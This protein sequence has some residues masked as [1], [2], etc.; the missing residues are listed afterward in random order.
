MKGLTLTQREQARLQVLNQ[1]LL[2]QITAREAAQVLALSE[3]HL[4]RLLATYRREGPASLAH[5]S[6]GRQPVNT[7]PEE[8]RRQ[9]VLLARTTLRSILLAAGMDSPRRR[10]PPQH[11]CRRQRMPQEGMLLQLDGSPHAW[12]EERGPWLTLLLAVDDAT[13]TVPYALF[14]EQEDTQ[15]YFHLLQGIIQRHGIP[16][17]VYTD[18]YTVFW[19]PRQRAQEESGTGTRTQFGRAVRELGV[20]QVFA[21]SPEA[22]GRVERTNGTFQDRL[23]AE[24]RLAGASNLVE[25][26]QVR[27]AFLPRF[28]ERFGVPA[29][30]SGNAYRQPD[31][32]LDVAGILCFKERRRVARDNTV[33]YHQH[34]LQLFPTADRPS[35]ARLWVEVQDRLDGQLLVSYRGKVLTPQEAPPLA[36]QLRAQAEAGS[37]LAVFPEPD[38]LVVSPPR[39][40]LAGEPIWY[41][42]PTRKRVHRNLV[43]A[44]MERARQQGKQIGRPRVSQREGFLVQWQ[45]VLERLQAGKVSRRGAAKELGIGYATLKRLLDSAPQLDGCQLEQPM[46]AAVVT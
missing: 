37:A 25:A 19:N 38:P 30:L 17:G 6:R 33:Q 23:V 5:G 16:L 10:R 15:G 24:L 29:A 44:G 42:D 11:R 31:P 21:H 45:G 2:K 18:R 20:G 35:Y 39:G 14:R 26:N 13:G 34:T 41:E 22:K 32:D 9:V 36:A 28:N 40:P 4:W 12:L 8:T 46:A 3:R 27:Q 43:R 1:V 7:I